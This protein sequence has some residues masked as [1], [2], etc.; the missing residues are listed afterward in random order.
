MF[1]NLSS[2]LNRHYS[3]NSVIVDQIKLLFADGKVNEPVD[4]RDAALLLLFDLT[5][6][7]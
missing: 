3:C 1:C 7:S 5:V 2:K 6:F 4:V